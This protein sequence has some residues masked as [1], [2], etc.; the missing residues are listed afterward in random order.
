MGEVDKNRERQEGAGRKIAAIALS[1]G[2]L[3]AP[4]IAAGAIDMDAIRAQFA[5]SFTPG[6][7]DTGLVAEGS[8]LGL[9]QDR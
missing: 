2:A 8:R 3:T 5:T 9:I 7:S 1:L 6:S 4:A